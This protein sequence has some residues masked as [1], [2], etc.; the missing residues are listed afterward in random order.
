M[1][2]ENLAQLL[3]NRVDGAERRGWFLEDEPDAGPAEAAPLGLRNRRELDA[4]ER[5][6]ATVE[7]HAARQELHRRQRGQGLAAAGLANQG[8]RLPATHGER[9]SVQDGG[10][11]T[12]H[13]DADADLVQFEKGRLV[14]PITGPGPATRPGT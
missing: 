4:V 12:R 11:P 14:R 2:G 6:Q 1:R 9:D 13:F 10:A 5:D 8:E 3:A 7:P